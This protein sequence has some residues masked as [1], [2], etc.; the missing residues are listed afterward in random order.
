[1]RGYHVHPAFPSILVSPFIMALRPPKILPGTLGIDRRPV[2]ELVMMIT[3]SALRSGVASLVLITSIAALCGCGE[4]PNA[5]RPLAATATPQGQPGSVPP[6]PPGAIE[7][8][9]SDSEAQQFATSFEKTLAS[10][11]T[12]A[13]NAAINI[14][15][16]LRRA[17]L[18]IDL[19]QNVRQNL[20]NGA[21]A[22]LTGPEGIAPGLTKRV[23]KGG[24]F[25][26]LHVHR[27]GNEQRALFR[28]TNDQ[29][30]IDYLDFILVRDVDGKVRIGDSYDYTKG[31]SDSDDIHEEGLCNAAATSP[32][33]L[34]KLCPMDRDYVTNVSAVRK[35][36]ELVAA[37][38]FREALDIYQGM[39]Q[40]LKNHRYVL[41]ERVLACCNLEGQFDE[42]ILAFRAAFPADPGID[43]YLL[44]YY[45]LH[46]QFDDAL[47]CIDRLDRA[48]GGDPLLDAYRV[49][50]HVQKGNLAAAKKCAQNALAAEPESPMARTSSNLVSLI[51]KNAPG[52]RPV[53]NSKLP[54]TSPGK[55]A[56]DAE[57]RAFADAFEKT[58]MSSDAA[59]VGAAIDIA[60]VNRRAI[61]KLNVSEETRVGMEIGFASGADAGIANRF[62]AVGRPQIEQGARFRLLHLHRTSGEQRALF[63]LVYPNGGV[64]YFDCILVRHEDGKVRIDDVYSFHAGEMLSEMMCRILSLPA[65]KRGNSPQAALAGRVNDV[66]RLASDLSEMTKRINAAEYQEALDIYH[67]LPD[68]LQKEKTMLLARIRAAHGLMG[69]AYDEAV[70]DYRKEFPN[71]P[72]LDLIMIDAYSSHKLFDRVLASIDGLD[73]TVGGDPYLDALRGRVYLLK[74]DLAAAKACARKSVEAEPDV[75]TAYLSLL[76][77]SLKEKNFA[78]TSALLTA[79]QEKFPRRM[80]VLKNNPAYAEYTSSP[81]Y[82]D[83]LNAKKP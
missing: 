44:N 19:P 41:Q 24:R 54:E 69:E 34:G 74:G 22:F 23:A 79:V 26:L 62:F 14:D 45:P 35:M 82:R 31:E 46:R 75:P 42:A 1:M 77:I 83:W 30:G 76:T 3:T 81:Q 21:K 17:I 60:A 5:N 67:G 52:D 71:E 29:G 55:P 27:Q 80:P 12:A 9:P 4:N 37:K 50:I 72:N 66:V 56:G 53:G 65:E 38:R 11:D 73:R 68:R 32:E 61:A 48:V 51:E 47:A 59:T 40:L 16:L 8:P 25:R 20:A 2:S 78:E 39:P 10:G 6:P 64:A 43:V 58:V 57:A 36:G 13:I 7:I 63:R 70:R 33:L 18:G 15:A 28:F 49:I